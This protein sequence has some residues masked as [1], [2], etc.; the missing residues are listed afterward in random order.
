MRKVIIV[1]LI[2]LFLGCIGQKKK[3]T[4][5]E[6]LEIARNFVLNSPTYKFDGEDL[7]YIETSK[8]KCVYC[9]QFVFKFTSRSAGYGDRSGQM[10]AQ[11]ITPHEAVIVVENGKVTS[12]VLDGKWDMINQ[13]MIE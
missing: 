6:S 8:G 3:F 7:R 5:E 1:T 2:I 13:K 10:V 12:A 9:W 4:E 11:M